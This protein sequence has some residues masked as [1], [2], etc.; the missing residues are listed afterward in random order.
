[1]FLPGP[2]IFSYTLPMKSFQP[3]NG[4]FS[5]LETVLRLQGL[6]RYRLQPLGL[7]TLQASM[8]LYLDRHPQCEV[9]EIASALCIPNLTAV[10]TV[11]LIQRNGWIGK[12]RVNAKRKIVKLQLTARGTALA[13]KVRENIAVTDKLFALADSRKAA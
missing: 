4:K 3:N 6:F 12:P 7:S 5:T 8:L 13:Q 1:M 10:E 2:T 11:Q 9:F